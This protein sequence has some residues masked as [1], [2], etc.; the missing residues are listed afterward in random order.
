MASIKD[1]NPMTIG[2]LL[3]YTMAEPVSGNI[4]VCCKTDSVSYFSYYVLMPTGN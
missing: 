4:G 1:P 2:C 3:E